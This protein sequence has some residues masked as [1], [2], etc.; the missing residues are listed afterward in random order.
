MLA[1]EQDERLPI[2]LGNAFDGAPKNGFLLL[3][4]GALRRERIGVRGA[5]RSLQGLGGME[6]F[7]SIPSQRLAD[8]IARDAAEPGAQARRLAQPRKLLPG[9]KER[10]LREV[11]A[12]AQAAGGGVSQRADEGLVALDDAAKGIPVAL[13]AF[14]HQL[15]IV[16][17]RDGHFFC[18]HHITV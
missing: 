6:G 7:A 3:A 11:F 10:L 15:R 12:L 1:V 9:D 17:L 13:Q 8:Q 18:R 16:V 14:R 4:D 5:L 2:D